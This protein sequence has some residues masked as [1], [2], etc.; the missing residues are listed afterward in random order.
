[1]AGVTAKHRAKRRRAGLKDAKRIRAIVVARCEW[2]CQRCGVYC[3]ENGHAH[4]RIPRSR[5]GQWTVENIEYLCNACHMEAHRT[6][7]L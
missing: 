4:H 7:T 2:S 6:N 5:G 3:G 1:M